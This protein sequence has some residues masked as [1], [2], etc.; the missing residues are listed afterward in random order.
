VRIVITNLGSLGNVQPFL[1]LAGELQRAGHHP[2]LALAPQYVDYV[3]SLGFEL[4]PIGDA[5]DYRSLQKRDTAGELRGTDP[6]QLFHE[7]L[8]LLGQMLPRMFRELY[9]ACRHAEVLVSGHLQPASRMIHE[10]TGMP[11]V[12]IHTSHF[13]QAQPHAF[14]DAARAIVNPFRA[15]HRL[16]PIDDPFHT[17]ANSEQLAIY[18]MS[19]YL[20]PPDPAW[21]PWYHATGFFFLDRDHVAV[22]PELAAFVD[23]GPP[24]IVFTFSSIA[25]EDPDAMTRL[26]AR[27]VDGLGRRAVILGGW[28]GLGERGS[29]PSSIH[30]TPFAPHHWLF[31]RAACVVHAGGSGTTAMALRAGVPVVVVPHVG[32]QPIWAELLRG[33]GCA[34]HIV[35]YRSLTA[36]ALGEAIAG[37]LTDPDVARNAARMAERIRDEPGVGGARRLIEQLLCRLGVDAPDTDDEDQYSVRT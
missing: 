17:G 22:D 16:P 19:R 21:P 2:I 10:I 6:L 14:R 12:S 28:S 3:G 4:A 25:H 26:L 37:T 5:I 18:A 31:P 32:D 1:A 20:R 13:G 33:I 35:P 9:D 30:L 34:K 36:D 15:A 7:S 23:S 24:P 29:L 27:S 8:G 11:F